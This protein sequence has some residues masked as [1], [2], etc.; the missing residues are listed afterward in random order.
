MKKLIVLLLL[1]ASCTTPKS[2][3]TNPETG[4]VATCGGNTSGSIMLGAVGYYMQKSDDAKC[5]ADYL[6]QGFKR[7]HAN[8]AQKT[9]SVAHK[10][11]E[12][13]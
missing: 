4:Q 12:E 10:N 6:E 3:L 1:L 7:A 2:V 13:D 8:N 9:D 5:E 11:K